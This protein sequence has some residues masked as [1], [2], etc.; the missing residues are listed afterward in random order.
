M[1][2]RDIIYEWLLIENKEEI[3]T[4][5]YSDINRNL[6][7]RIIKA[8]PKTIVNNNEIIQFGKHSRLL[9]ELYKKDGLEI[10]DL[11]KA[12]L[13]L[14]I[15]YSENLSIDYKKINGIY[16]LYEI[17]KDRMPKVATTLEQILDVLDENEYSIVM[18]SDSWIIIEP[19]SEKAAAYIGVNT[20]WCTTWGKYCFNSD[21]KSRSNRYQYYR[22][23]GPFYIIINKENLND[24]YQLHF[25]SDQLMSPSN[26]QVPKR[27]EF[28]DQR[29]DVKKYFFPSLFDDNEDINK[30]KYQVK[31][32]RKFLSEEDVTK[33]VTVLKGHYGTDET[34][35]GAISSGEADIVKTFIT[36][37]NIKYFEFKRNSLLIGIRNF[38]VPMTD[39]REMI[40]EYRGQ[41][42]NAYDN[43][44]ESESYSYSSS[45]EDILGHYLESY[46]DRR[47]G[48]LIDNFGN[49]VKTY[50]GFFSTFFYEISEN[51][52]IRDNYLSEFATLTSP[53][54]EKKID[55]EIE[56]MRQHLDFNEG[57]TTKELDFPIE[58]LLEFI[59]ARDIMFIND[60]DDFIIDYCGYYDLP[61]DYSQIEYFE[62]DYDS[63][64]QEFMD[65]LFD[66]FFDDVVEQMKDEMSQD[67]DFTKECEN[68]RKKFID[69]TKKYFDENNQFENQFV[70][71]TI[72]NNWYNNFS[73]KNGIDVNYENK[74]TN[75][76]YD[77]YI[78][79]DNL[80]NYITMEP[81][82]ESIV[83]KI[84]KEVKGK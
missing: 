5:Y 52:R 35:A 27:P 73:C 42:N 31:Y 38:T 83:K 10:E 25:E 11:P 58:K 55:D 70:K 59:N 4:K 14:N 78:Q 17:V 28:F 68:S 20:E 77:G 51:D 72:P 26:K 44:Y 47:I 46:H 30:L 50:D 60:L 15:V 76:K 57:W 67:E 40:T 3:Y 39:Y 63:P 79:V 19:K 53:S 18:N 37:E 34:L 65:G 29:L 45:P 36:D 12:T 69:I 21:L 43:V 66:D 54:L 48:F 75:E 61:T 22:D 81:L 9:L 6:F 84:L 64:T 23:M 1:K 56:R 7:I 41:S 82:F 49:S 33:L 2:F 62:Y 8:D 24:K 32:A 80:I 74:K 16:D 71:I 13:Y